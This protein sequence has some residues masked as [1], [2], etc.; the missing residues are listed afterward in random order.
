MHDNQITLQD[1]LTE[2]LLYTTPQGGV[3]VEIFF[4]NE[5]IWLT[6][7]QM[8]E[9]F[10]IDR[11]VVSKHL[12]NIFESHELEEKKVCAKIAHTTQHGAIKGKSQTGKK[13]FKEYE[14]FNKT[15]KIDS[16][17]EKFSRNLMTKKQ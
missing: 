9:L 17:F 5:N 6:Q 7:K 11:S 8:A 10:G 16:D 14:K 12:K 1:E 15:Q 13:A 2:F 3:K 4:H